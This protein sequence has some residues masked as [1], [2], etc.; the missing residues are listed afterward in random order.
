MYIIHVIIG[1][2]KDQSFAGLEGRREK[3]SEFEIHVVQE[4]EP[5]SYSI[6]L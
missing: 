1:L 4:D 6:K 5:L 2:K 3:H